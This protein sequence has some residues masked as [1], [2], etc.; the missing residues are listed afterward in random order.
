MGWRYAVD[1]WLP[2]KPWL[3]LGESDRVSFDLTGAK[4]QTNTA[5]SQYDEFKKQVA[6]EMKVFTFTNR[7]KYLAYSVRGHEVIPFWS[8]RNRVVTV[9]KAHPQYQQYAITEMSLDEFIQWFP[10]LA[11]ERIHIGTNWSGKQLIGYDVST[12]ELK[13]GIEYWMNRDH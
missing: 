4:I 7:G 6:E 8:S 3:F 11:G 2:V 1:Q 12:D 13:A 5:A 9:Q 10:Q